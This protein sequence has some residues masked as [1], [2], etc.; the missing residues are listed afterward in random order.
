MVGVDA[1]SALPQAVVPPQRLGPGLRLANQVL[2]DG[3]RDVVAVKRSLEGALVAAGPRVEQVALKD[4]VVERRVRVDGVVVELVELVKRGRP[5]VL[6]AIRR[7]DGAVLTVGQ[8]RLG[9]AGQLHRR[10]LDVGGRQRRV[11]VVRRRGE[12]ARQRQ[13]VFT[14]V[15]Q[16]VLLLPIQVLERE[17]VDRQLGTRGQ[18]GADLR[19]RDLQQLGIEPRRGLRRL[20]EQNLDLLSACVDLVVALVL[21]VPKRREVPHLVF[22]LADLV[23]E[24]Q[25]RQQ[26]LAPLAKRSLEC[27]ERIDLPVELGV[28]R[29]PLV[30]RGED[31][32]QV[33]LESLGDA[34][35]VAERR[36]RRSFGRHCR[37]SY[38]TD[39]RGRAGGSTGPHLAVAIRCARRADW[40]ATWITRCHG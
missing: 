23:A 6:V 20:G 16:D 11:G 17:T 25:R 5:V 15:V 39:S 12:P 4:A 40:E 33:P 28:G 3:G 19:Q 22:E 2:D 10:V 24:A 18:P 14:L 13:Q 29:L 30:P 1:K 32:L 35:A 7:E 36:C 9:A 37:R 21:V 31:V 27:R 38:C 26:R 8:R 34:V